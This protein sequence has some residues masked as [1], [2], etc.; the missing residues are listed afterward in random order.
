MQLETEVR[1]DLFKKFV[2]TRAFE[3]NGS[4]FN[5]PLPLYISA[6][7][8]LDQYNSMQHNQ[9]N[10][11]LL[12]HMQNLRGLFSRDILCR[13]TVQR[14]CFPGQCNINQRKN[15]Y[16]I[17]EVEI[18]GLYFLVKMYK[19][20]EGRANTHLSVEKAVEDGHHQTLSQHQVQHQVQHL[21]KIHLNSI[22]NHDIKQDEDKDKIYEKYLEG[23]EGEVEEYFINF[24]DGLTKKDH[25][26]DPKEGD[27]QQGGFG[28]TPGRTDETTLTK[29]FNHT[30]CHIKNLSQFGRIQ[31]SSD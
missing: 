22:I 12:A 13:L 6:I 29:S 10:I 14:F 16:T 2:K 11:I 17:K 9:C 24:C 18:N 23:S 30:L 19:M 21:V 7:S 27:E 4:T 31:V 8:Q 20:V 26:V 5:K 1:S 28:Q 3:T 15:A 25:V